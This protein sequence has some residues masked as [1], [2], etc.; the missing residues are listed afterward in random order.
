M[1]ILNGKNFKTSIVIATFFSTKESNINLGESSVILIYSITISS[2]IIFSLIGPILL[3]ICTF[4]N[5]A[6]VGKQQ[7]LFVTN[8][9]NFA[10]LL[11][12]REVETF[13]QH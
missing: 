12:L 3:W 4:F 6:V 7:K 10:E 13:F 5:F 8:Q 9:R 1:Y 2:I 11:V